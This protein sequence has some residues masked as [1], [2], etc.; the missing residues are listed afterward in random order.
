MKDI[1][2][3]KPPTADRKCPRLQMSLPYCKSLSRRLPC[4]QCVLSAVIPQRSEARLCSAS[5][6]RHRPVSWVFVTVC[7]ALKMDPVFW[8]K[9]RE[10]LQAGD[11]IFL[12]HLWQHACKPD[13]EYPLLSWAL[14][15]HIL[16]LRLFSTEADLQVERHFWF[17][18]FASDMMSFYHPPPPLTPRSQVLLLRSD[19]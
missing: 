15:S 16:N 2:I 1:I 14:Y 9:L 8:T 11:Y 6:W 5:F 13:G 7:A 12:I 4:G 17:K 19:R 10:G 18:L 3:I